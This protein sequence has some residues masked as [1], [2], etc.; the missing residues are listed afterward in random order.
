MREGA[1]RAAEGRRRSRRE[2]WDTHTRLAALL[3]DYLDP[4]TTFWS[5]L[6]N[7]PRSL[8]SGLFAK[9]RGV[10]SGLPDVMV[11]FRQRPNSSGVSRG[12]H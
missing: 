8:L 4:R 7:S 12:K 2:E 10:K 1:A 9:R 3:Q 6:E 11:I 5:S